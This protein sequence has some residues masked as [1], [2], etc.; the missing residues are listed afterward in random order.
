MM[1]DKDIAEILKK[2]DEEFKKLGAEHKNLEKALS[3][4]QS[5]AYLT[6]EEEFEKK[7][8][9]KL[10]L[11]KKDKMAERIRQYKKRHSSLN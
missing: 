2:E 1:E 4:F 6:P 7:R 5:K 11:L 8:V 10:K 9:Q 3:E